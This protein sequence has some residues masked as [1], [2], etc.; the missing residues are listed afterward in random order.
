[1]VDNPDAVAADGQAHTV[2]V[3]N[4]GTGSSG[5]VSVIN[6]AT[7]SATNTTGCGQAPAVLSIG[8]SGGAHFG[9]A[10]NLAVDQARQLD[11]AETPETNTPC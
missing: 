4:A 2:Y 1:M 3:A 5:T 7:C 6:A 8:D 9:S 11:K 10:L